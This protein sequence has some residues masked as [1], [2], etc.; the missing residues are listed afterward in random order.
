MKRLLLLTASVL[1][2]SS[3]LTSASAGDFDWQIKSRQAVMQLNAFNV[4]ILAAMAK[5]DMDYDA[6]LAKASAENLLAITR[7]NNG[8]M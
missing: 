3:V 8:A 4:G 1:F 6:D 7:M 2:A 5:G